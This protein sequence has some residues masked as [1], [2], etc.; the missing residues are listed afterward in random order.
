MKKVFLFFFIAFIIF[1]CGKEVG[2]S[3]EKVLV[4]L[5]TNINT[6]SIEEGHKFSVKHNGNIVKTKAIKVKGGFALSIKKKRALL[7]KKELSFYWTKQR[8]KG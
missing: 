6:F 8:M 7:S 4:D 2:K 1:S 5:S 3:E